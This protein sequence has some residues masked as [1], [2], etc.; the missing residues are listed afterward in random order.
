L[1]DQYISGLYEF[2]AN[3]RVR[4]A[5]NG[6]ATPL[7]GTYDLV[8]PRPSVFGKTVAF[9]SD[10]IGGGTSQQAVFVAILNR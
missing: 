10:I 2:S 7:G 9:V 5:E 4:I 8:D 6:F 1:T 3:A